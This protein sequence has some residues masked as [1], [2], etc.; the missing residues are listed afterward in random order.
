[1]PHFEVIYEGNLRCQATHLASGT[2]ISTDAPLD[3]HGKGEY[4]SPT[5]LLA[6]SLATCMITV[7]GIEA[8]HQNLDISDTVI[9]VKKTMGT[10]PRRVVEIGI[11]MRIPDRN[12]TNSQKEKLIEIGLNCPVAKSIHP[13]IKQSIQ[14]DFITNAFQ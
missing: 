9:E 1:M 11:N 5:D 10:L 13:D 4:F 8:K 12:F 14:I 6:T 2:K 3:N 7:M